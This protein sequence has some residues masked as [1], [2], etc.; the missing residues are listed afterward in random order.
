[1]ERL[2]LNIR[3][4]VQGVGFRYTVRQQALKLGLFG[5]VK[6]LPDGSVAVVAEGQR[7][8]L[9]KFLDWCYTGVGSSR[10]DGIDAVWEEATGVYEDFNMHT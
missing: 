6:N 5:W 1:M 3:G 10:V 9:Q 2:E 8:R 7:E 4:A